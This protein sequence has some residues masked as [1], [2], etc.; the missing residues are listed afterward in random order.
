[1]KKTPNSPSSSTANRA[2][3]ETDIELSKTALL[4]IDMQKDLVKTEG[5][6]FAPLFQAIQ[7]NK[8][9]ENIARV[10]KGARETKVP[11]WHI[12]TVHRKDGAD[13]VPT[14]TDFMLQGLVPKEMGEVMVEGTPG[15]D[16]IDELR[17][18]AEDYVV[19]KRRSSAFHN[20]DLDLLL[21]TRGIDT[22]ILAGV[23]TNGCVENTSRDARQRDYHVLVLSDCCAS[24]MPE[25][26]DYAMNRVFPGMGR[27]RTSDEMLAVMKK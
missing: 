1:M 3:K 10:I 11:I 20:T 18:A 7:S 22:L 9:I 8:V 25:A 19:V 4:V 13:V 15:A 5:G 26:H 14:I 6:Y 27:V 2:K 16:F 12:A 21:R 24:I 17:P 23:V